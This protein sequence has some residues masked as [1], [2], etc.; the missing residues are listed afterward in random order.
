M[1]RRWRVRSGGVWLA[2]TDSGSGNPV[3]LLHGL[4][5]TH[6]WWDLVA[7]KLTELRVVR[8]DFRGHG[9]SDAPQA[10]Y[11]LEGLASDTLTILDDL[12]LDRVV[13]AGHS[14]GAAVALRVAVAHPRRV[15]ALAFVDG[16]VYDSRLLFGTDWE[17]ARTAMVLPRRGQVTMAVLR[18][19]LESTSLPA[20][21]FGSILA[22]YRVTGPGGAL[23]LRLASAHEEQL[24]YDLWQ[25]DPVPLLTALCAPTLLLAARQ[26]DQGHDRPRQESIER[27][28]A[29]TADLTVQWIDGGHD[30]PLQRPAE[31]AR[32]LSSLA[33]NFGAH[34]FGSADGCPKRTPP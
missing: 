13:L 22:N 23:Q 21:A 24:A 3:V 16:G 5:S 15:A 30:L 19:W 32:A 34:S 11:D 2:G 7:E 20:A 12:D 4:A 10:G 6:R 18:A 27:A 8:F 29:A 14:L 26:H 31:V 1:S 28:Q 17:Q 33:H 9:Q 25:Q